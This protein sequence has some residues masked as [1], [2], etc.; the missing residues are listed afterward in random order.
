MRPYQWVSV[1]CAGECDF[2]V[3]V[4]ILAL[5]I[6]CRYWLSIYER[7]L[8]LC[9]WGILYIHFC[10]NNNTKITAHMCIV[11]TIDISWN[12]IHI[13]VTRF[14]FRCKFLFSFI[15]LTI[16]FDIRWLDTYT[17]RLLCHIKSYN[18]LFMRFFCWHFISF[19]DVPFFF[20]ASMQINVLFVKREKIF[21]NKNLPT[22]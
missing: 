18:Y 9:W 22:K 5:L 1:H 2:F 3:A 14:F 21:K 19:F 4:V 20:L 6:T 7:L 10:H 11:R 17:N 15:H 12:F 8:W 16:W 13:L